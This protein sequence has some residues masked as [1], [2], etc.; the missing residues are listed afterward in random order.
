MRLFK[1]PTHRR[2]AGWTAIGVGAVIAA[3][4]FGT[5]MADYTDSHPGNIGGTIGSIWI[6]PGADLNVSFNN[7]LPGDAQTMTLPFTN[8]G[9]SNQDVW[10]KFPNVTALSALNTLGTYGEVHVAV[11]G[12]P[13]FDSANLNDRLTTCGAFS[14]TGCW[15]LPATLKLASNVAPGAGGTLTFS[16][17]YAAKMKTQAPA[18]T[19]PLFNVWPLPDQVTT[20]SSDGTGNGLPFVLEAVQVNHQP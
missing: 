17:K 20:V 16:F 18:D 3:V 9:R 7:L 11:N 15:P 13:V 12:V 4:G 19:V 10:L 8:T 14:P 5:S 1:A 2:K 6:Q